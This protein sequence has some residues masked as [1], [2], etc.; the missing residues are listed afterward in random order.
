MCLRSKAG[1]SLESA[2]RPSVS[3]LGRGLPPASAWAVGLA[4]ARLRSVPRVVLGAQL[5]GGQSAGEVGGVGASGAVEQGGEQR[6]GGEDGGGGPVGGGVA[7]DGGVL[8]ECRG[9]GVEA[10]VA[11]GGAGGQRA[12]QGDADGAA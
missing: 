7:V 2:C 10:Q 9:A 4:G 3:T 1:K 6:A 11:G 5:S 8:V 12:E